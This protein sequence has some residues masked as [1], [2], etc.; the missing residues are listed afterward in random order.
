VHA[1]APVVSWPAGSGVEL[2]GQTTGHVPGRSPDRHWGQPLAIRNLGIPA[3]TEYADLI[4]IK[5]DL[6]FVVNACERLCVELAKPE[7]D[8]KPVIDQ[9][10]WTA[11]LVTYARCFGSGKRTPGLTADDVALLP[12]EGQIAEWHQYL[13]DGKVAALRC[14]WM[15]ETDRAAPDLGFAARIVSP[16]GLAAWCASR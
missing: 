12:L 7:T 6:E 16:D 3:A 4:S 13:I 5:Q 11:A 14:L 10:L 8:R 9:S 2:V 1:A 15:C